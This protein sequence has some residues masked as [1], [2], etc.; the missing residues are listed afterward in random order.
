M[1]M[2]SGAERGREV[3]GRGAAW[4]AES[5]GGATAS[6]PSAAPEDPAASRAIAWMVGEGP[7]ATLPARASSPNNPPAHGARTG[8]AADGLRRR[9][10]HRRA[11]IRSRGPGKRGRHRGRPG[12]GGRDRQGGGWGEGGAVRVG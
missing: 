8:G 11:R 5:V 9:R 12:T 3:G 1:P 7:V 6:G 4:A 10:E 2:R